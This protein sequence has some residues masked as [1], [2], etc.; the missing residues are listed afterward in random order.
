MVLQ[1]WKQ[2][3]LLQAKVLT[4]MPSPCIAMNNMKTE[5]EGLLAE[6]DFRSWSHQLPCFVMF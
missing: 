5:L 2:G 1:M 6:M 3:R 4:N